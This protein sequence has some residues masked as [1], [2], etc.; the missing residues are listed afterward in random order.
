MLRFTVLLAGILLLA[1][2]LSAGASGLFALGGVSGLVDVDPI[3]L[4][5]ARMAN[6]GLALPLAASTILVAGAAN[7]AAKSVLA[8]VFG[9]WRLGAMLGG[10]AL[11][12]FGAG[13]AA[14]F[15]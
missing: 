7:G 8:I 6:T 5:M 3:T 2:F 15:I 12:A 4:S 11:L 10:L 13:A 1:K 9:G 14:Y